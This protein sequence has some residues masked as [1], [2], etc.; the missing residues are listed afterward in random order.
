MKRIFLKTGAS[1]LCVLLCLAAA[2]ACAA[3]SP[4]RPAPQPP[5][6]P[7][8]KTIDLSGYRLI[9]A[10]EF[11]G[12]R[13]NWDLWAADDPRNVKHATSRGPEAVEVRD[14]E[15][16]LNVRRVDR[17]ERVK[18]IAGYVYLREPLERNVYVE[19]RFRSGASSGVNN[20]FWL[21][22]KT[23]PNTSW[24]N[25]YEIDIVEAR[26]DVRTGRGKGHLAYHDWKTY[27]YARDRNGAECDI[28]AGIAVE[29]D[30]DRYHV[31]GLWYGENELIY[32]L[33]G[34]ELWRGTTS[35]SYPEQYY[36][37]VGKAP[38][39]NPL[40]E[41][42][43]YGNYGQ[44]DWNYLGGYNGDRMHVVLANIP[45][46]AA[47]SPLVEEE[48]D[49]TWMAVDYVRIYKPEAL[50]DPTPDLD[51]PVEAAEIVLDEPC[52]LAEEACYYFSAE[53]VKRPGEELTLTFDDPQ[54]GPVARVIVDADGTLLAGITRLASSRFAASP[55]QGL[56]LVADDA[57]MLLV[58][59]ITA[60][61]GHGRY[62]RDAISVWCVP[63]CEAAEAP[64][65]YFYPN[66]DE[67]GNTSATQEWHVGQ[68]GY[69]DEVVRSVRFESTRGELSSFGRFRAGRNFSSVTR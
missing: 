64:E 67:A 19:C 49:G 53:I 42:R 35:P 40:E 21:A 36:T 41:R 58:C 8:A 2:H 20:A 43:A 68:K 69:S 23:P 56:R 24:C 5:A 38:E 55:V 33:D 45:W 39:W 1:L 11:D 37:G 15:L 27:S 29:H 13:M 12:R 46:G 28:A 9:F 14:G 26:K 31:W 18:W 7:P 6:E 50:L 51:R 25:K 48:A 63:A 44:E 4:E 66:L 61:V 22:C 17:S 57:K 34:E 32:Y 59:R 30:F 54:N 65:P 47:W 10:D 60:R 16:R 3:Q 52:S 62:D